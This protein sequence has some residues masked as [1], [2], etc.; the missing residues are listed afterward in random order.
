M[1]ILSRLIDLAGLRT[2]LD[3]RCRL[4][5]AFAID[6]EPAGRGV[7]P[8]HVVLSG[9]CRLRLPDGR[10]AELTAGD[11]LMLPRGEAHLIVGWENGDRPRP[12][13]LTHDGMLPV[14][15]NGEGSP[16]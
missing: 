12:V 8:F 2:S 13:R 5:G 1:D 11:F 15:E 9:R 4:E 7:V 16:D 3:I 14:R 10:V 6:H